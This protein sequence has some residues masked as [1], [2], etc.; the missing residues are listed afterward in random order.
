MPPSLLSL[1]SGLVYRVVKDLPIEDA[2]SFLLY[3]RTIYDNS[4][5]AFDKKCFRILLVRLE[6]HGLLTAED[7]LKK[8]PYCFLEKI[9]IQINPAVKLGFALDDLKGH[10]ASILTQAL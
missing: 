6:H 9:F 3:C 5:H 1:S 2:R 10:L 4:K 7:I 8:Q